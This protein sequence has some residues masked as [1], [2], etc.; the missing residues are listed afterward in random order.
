MWGREGRIEEM[1]GGLIPSG[2]KR[3]G[4]AVKDYRSISA[5]VQDASHAGRVRNV[6]LDVW[7]GNR[8]VREDGGREAAAGWRL[9]A[10]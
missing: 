8:L 7:R 6:V 10:W 3:G 1:R 9:Q 5:P 2:R 4:G